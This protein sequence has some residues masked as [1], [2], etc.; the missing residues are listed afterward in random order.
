MSMHCAREHPGS[1]RLEPLPSQCLV[2]RELVVRVLGARPG[3]R[4][5]IS[6]RN[7]GANGSFFAASATF[8]ADRDGT[9]DLT[10]HAPVDGSYRNVH[11]MG[12][13]W[14]RVQHAGPPPADV[15]EDPLTAILTVSAAGRQ[16]VQTIRRVYREDVTSRIIQEDGLVGRFITP[17]NAGPRPAVLVVGGSG[18]GL[19]WSAQVAALLACHGFS[20][21][22]LSYFGGEGQ[23]SELKHIPLEYF[24]GAIDWLGK[25]AEVQNGQIGMLGCS[26]GGELAL[27]VGAH[28]PGVRAVVA[29]VPSVIVGSGYPDGQSPAWTWRDRE[30]PFARDN[31]GTNAITT[32]SFYSQLLQRGSVGDLCIE[33]ERIAGPVMLIS[34]R[35]DGVWPSAELADLAVKRMRSAGFPHQLEHLSYEDAGHDIAWPNAPT[36]M[37]RFQHPLTGEEL[38]AGGTAEGTAY[39]SRNSWPRMLE[40]LRSA[41]GLCQ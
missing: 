28:Y 5:E 32:H 8:I 24:G 17:T 41:L 35:A 27:L 6:L 19:G 3:E 37:N 22:A 18:G 39:A 20:T 16:V 1:M 31:S 23:P 4:V 29:Y 30:V 12:L 36:T 9:V 7:A 2:D 10:A 25:Q 15:P 13:F 38:D 34:G 21:L 26:R 11:P 14:S 40:F 33:V